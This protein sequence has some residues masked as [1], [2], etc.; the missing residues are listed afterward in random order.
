MTTLYTYIVRRG[1]NLSENILVRVAGKR[2]ALKAAGLPVTL[3]KASSAESRWGKKV[4]IE[5]A[6]KMLEA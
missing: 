2:R 6:K 5:E 4:S 1:A 3:K